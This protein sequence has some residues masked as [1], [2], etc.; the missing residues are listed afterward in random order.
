VSIPTRLADKDP[1]EEVLVTFDFSDGATVVSDPVVGSHVRWSGTTPPD[2]APSAVLSGPPIV[3]GALVY[4]KVVGGSDMTDY[5]LDCLVTTSTG[6]KL[7][8]PAILPVRTKRN[9]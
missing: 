8:I 6:D 5:S 4:Q 7:L 2:S 3:V 9:Q 1:A